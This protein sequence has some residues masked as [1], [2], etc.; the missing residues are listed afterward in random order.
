MGIALVTGAG[1][2]LGRAT[3]TRLASDGFDVVAVD[4][5]AESAAV[6]AEAVG[7]TGYP[8]DVADR[9]AVRE[10][11]LAVGPIEVLVN[12][13]GIWTYGPILEADEENLD[14]VLSVN[15]MGTLNCCRAF[16]PSMVAGGRGVVVN[17]SSAAAASAAGLVEMYSV[18]KGAIETLTRQLAQD[19]GPQGVRV[20]A[21]APGQMFT[22]GTAPSYAGDLFEAR[23]KT[24]PLR[25]IGTPED[26]AN[27]V[28]FLVS[29]QASY[30]TGQILHV[31]G[32]VT[33]PNA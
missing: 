26:I 8:C 32:G 24:V 27:A 28:S 6:T 10:L 9:Q 12:N 13:A 19:L 20:N 4:L 5:D 30:I 33:A 31:D 15:L 16:I 11:A 29:E 7:G 23:A 2:G 1:R 18:S 22:E 25:R 14:R 3:A 21:I 17:L